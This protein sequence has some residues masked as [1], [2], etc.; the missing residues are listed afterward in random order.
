[1]RLRGRSNMFLQAR[2]AAELKHQKWLAHEARCVLHLFV[3]VSLPE[4]IHADA[5]SRSRKPFHARFT[6]LL[7]S[8]ALAHGHLLRGLSADASA[9]R[10]KT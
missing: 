7:Q 6:G 2:I 5:D 10:L 3:Q 8:F 9:T 4:G 1:M